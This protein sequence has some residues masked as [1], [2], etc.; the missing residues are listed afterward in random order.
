MALKV[1]G[2]WLTWH[3]PVAKRLLADMTMKPVRT[4][5]AA[6]SDYTVTTNTIHVTVE[7]MSGAI[8][9]AGT[10]QP[11]N[12]VDDVRQWAA[13]A[14]LKQQAWTSFEA[15]KVV[16]HSP[17][18]LRDAIPTTMT[19]SQLKTQR[20]CAGRSAL[21]DQ[22]NRGHLGTHNMSSNSN[23]NNPSSRLLFVATMVKTDFWVIPT[24]FTELLKFSEDR[25][26]VTGVGN[27]KRPPYVQLHRQL[28]GDGDSFSVTIASL[29]ANFSVGIVAS[30]QRL[31]PIGRAIGH[32][33]GSMGVDGSKWHHFRTHNIDSHPCAYIRREG[34]WCRQR[35]K[36]FRYGDR[37]TFRVLKAERCGGNS[38]LGG[39]GRLTLQ[40]QLNDEVL[41]DELIPRWFSPPLRA[42][43]TL[44]SG[45]ALRV[46]D[47]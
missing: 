47:E 15:A 43:C 26:T 7:A 5:A 19:L 33:V 13:E 4:R 21:Q 37:L 39:E 12:T 40:I 30:T 31:A 32:A 25:R 11:T 44:R 20:R 1:I 42:V 10:F 34:Q 16:L 46:G 9:A 14:G 8:V 27:S 35:R 23:N 6:A 29:G 3:S 24:S 36:M 22:S 38:G 28:T 45:F 18:N 17:I 2:M 41:C